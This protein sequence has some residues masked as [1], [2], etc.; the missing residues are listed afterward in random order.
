LDIDPLKKINTTLGY[1]IGDLILK[2]VA[3]VIK[4]N[5]DLGMRAFRY[6]GEEF[7]I[8]L[9]DL[10]VNSAFS[11]AERI[12]L[13]VQNSKFFLEVLKYSEITIST[14]IASYP[15]DSS[16]VNEI[17]ELSKIAM[18]YSK[19]TGRNRSTI[20]T[21]Y[22]KNKIKNKEDEII[23][24]D[25]LFQSVRSM[26]FALEA[27]DSYTGK[28]SINV[29][30]YSLIIA[31]AMNMDEENKEILITSSILHDCGKIGI[32]DSLLHKTS[33]L[34][35]EEY[36]I[37][38]NHS[39]IGYD[40]VN[41]FIENNLV[42][43]AIKGH[44]ERWDG[45]GYPDGLAGNDIPLFSRI[46]GIADSY[47]AMTSNRPYRN[48]LTLEEAL[49]EIEKSKGEQ[50]DPKIASIFIKEIKKMEALDS[51]KINSENSLFKDLCGIDKRYNSKI[52]KKAYDNKI[53]YTILLDRSCRI[54][55]TNSKINE[56]LSKSEDEIRTKK[57]YEIIMGRNNICSSCKIKEVLKEKKMQ[58]YIKE[59]VTSEGYKQ[60]LHQ[61]WVPIFD[62]DGE[63][64]SIL[65]L[66][67]PF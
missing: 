36:D 9:E 11:L 49:Y 51:K 2:F 46:I 7:A 6:G 53:V 67:T 41:N 1:T 35:N 55:H 56:F 54:I 39:Q 20:Y 43:N 50:F 65:E 8:I 44:H 27:R 42:K 32:P 48:A 4:K 19:K 33:K 5:L 62:A 60:V 64:E 45:K 12:R 37:I 66:A 3:H 31:E 63:V 29:K 57:C 18:K 15:K 10:D 25:Q 47:D 13:A 23:K 17:V 24:E 16:D 26:V 40:I 21:P 52:L 59:E 58:S 38:K 14:G 30:K 22:L 28:H 34:T 61:I